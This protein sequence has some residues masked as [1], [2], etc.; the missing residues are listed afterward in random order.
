M[1][2]SVVPT[3]AV[4]IIFDATIKEG[5]IC[6]AAVQ[7]NPQAEVH[8]IWSEKQIEVDPL[9][10]EDSDAFKALA[11]ALKAGFDRFLLEGD[12]CNAIQ[13]ILSPTRQLHWLNETMA[14]EILDLLSSLL[15]SRS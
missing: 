2:G 12:A 15:P 13:P 6:F 3:H 11:K 1:D 10:P 7:R 9:V 8:F 5:K 4:K 14:M